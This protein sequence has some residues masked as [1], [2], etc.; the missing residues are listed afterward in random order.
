MLIPLQG[1]EFLDLGLLSPSRGKCPGGKLLSFKNLEQK[2]FWLITIFQQRQDHRNYPQVQ[3]RNVKNVE[4]GIARLEGLYLWLQPP[5]HILG[6][7]M[8]VV[9]SATFHSHPRTLLPAHTEA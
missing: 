8:E 2:H 5:S 6:S 4:E 3:R 1:L 9:T 7:L